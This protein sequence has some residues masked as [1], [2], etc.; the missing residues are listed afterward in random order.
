MPQPTFFPNSILLVLDILIWH[1][2]RT[3]L[4]DR[5][6]AG[7]DHRIKLKK[8]LC[9]SRR[10]FSNH[11]LS[12]RFN[13]DTSANEPLKVLDS[14]SNPWYSRARASQSREPSLGVGCFIRRVLA[15]GA[16]WGEAGGRAADSWSAELELSFR[17]KHFQMPPLVH[18]PIWCSLCFLSARSQMSAVSFYI[19]CSV[20]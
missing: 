8:E 7:G 16:G 9:R 14:T 13:F 15:L 5:W 4:E 17:L 20:L 3:F 12:A 19:G 6:G 10:E 2:T 18:A 11:D 1:I